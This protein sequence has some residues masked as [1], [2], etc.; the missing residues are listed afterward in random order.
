MLPEHEWLARAKLLSVGMKL[1]IRHRQERRLNLIIGNDRDRYWCYCQ[2]CHEGGVVLKEHV[3]LGTPVETTQ[4]TLE[5]PKDVIT[6]HGSDW[7]VP[8]A[9]FLAEKNMALTFLETSVSI[10]PS[11]KRL[12]IYAD[13]WHGRDLT[14]KSLTKWM[15]Y[16][17]TQ[18]AS[19]YRMNAPCAVVVEDLFSMFKVRWACQQLD[20]NVI[21]ALGTGIKDALVNRLIDKKKII[22]FFDNDPA[23]NT[24]AVEGVK[25]MRPFCNN[26]QILLPPAGC[27]PKDMS[28]NDI[29]QKIGALL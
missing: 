19:C 7:E 17:N 11:R 14:G 3:R 10:S 24:G 2:R 15:N 29:N 8:V 25:R 16:S 20:V 23:G 28:C 9:R 6:L 26:Q 12:L 5:Y 13:G 22:W 18:I 21:C 1:R 27:D 4:D